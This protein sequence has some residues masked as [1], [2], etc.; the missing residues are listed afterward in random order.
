MSSGNSGPVGA[1]PAALPPSVRPYK[2]TPVFSQDTV[3][4]GLLK[5]HSTKPGV[6]GVITVLSGRLRYSVPATGEAAILSPGQPGVV[7]PTVSHRVKP[8]GEVTFSIEFW[9]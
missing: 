3:P 7:E 8:L 6:W 4:A 5:S 2:Q 1:K 9:R